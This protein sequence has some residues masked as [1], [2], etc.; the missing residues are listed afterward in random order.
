M[1][2]SWIKSHHEKWDGRGYPD[3]LKG[4]EIPLAGRIIALADTYD[5]MT[6]TRSYRKALPHEI[7]IEEIKKSDLTQ[8]SESSNVHDSIIESLLTKESSTI[9]ENIQIVESTEIIKSTQVIDTSKNLESSILEP[10]QLNESTNL[11]RT[12]QIDDSTQIQ[13]AELS[14]TIRQSQKLDMISISDSNLLTEKFQDI[15]SS[16]ISDSNKMTEKIIYKLNGF[17]KQLNNIFILEDLAFK[18]LCKPE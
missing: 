2:S 12:N 3:G 15:E 10:S 11:M 14:Q 16:I 17:L 18:K 4:E 1:I 9:F 5:A 13:I 7:A 6:S 8:I